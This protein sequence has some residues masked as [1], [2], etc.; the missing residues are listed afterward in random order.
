MDMGTESICVGPATYYELVASM[1]QEAWYYVSFSPNSV[2]KIFG[3]PLVV[4]S[5]I[6]DGE[7]VVSSKPTYVIDPITQLWSLARAREQ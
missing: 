3:K 4:I 7:I 2:A 6:P 5:G 1:A